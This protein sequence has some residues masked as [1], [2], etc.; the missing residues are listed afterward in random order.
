MR[1]TYTYTH[2]PSGKLTIFFLFLFLRFTWI[3]KKFLLVCLSVICPIY[4]KKNLCKTKKNFFCN[5]NEKEDK[6]FFILVLFFFV[7]K[8]PIEKFFFRDSNLSD[9][10]HYRIVFVFCLLLLLLLF[11]HTHHHHHHHHQWWPIG[12]SF[13]FLFFLFTDRLIDVMWCNVMMII[14]NCLWSTANTF[15]FFLFTFTPNKQTNKRSDEH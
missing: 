2:T 10:P 8:R 4:Q 5:E 15:D 3:D 9:F 6:T 11:T 13:F 1:H 12:S 14:I 7:Y